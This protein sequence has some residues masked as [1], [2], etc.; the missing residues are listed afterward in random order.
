MNTEFLVRVAIGVARLWFYD[1]EL[2][3]ADPPRV[4]AEAPQD[5]A[6][7]PFRESRRIQ[8][9]A[10][11]GGI[12]G[13]IPDGKAGLILLTGANQR[14][15]AY[16]AG[17][18]S[19]PIPNRLVWTDSAGEERQAVELPMSPR[20]LSQTDDGTVYVV[21]DTSIAWY[22]AKG[23]LLGQEEAPHFVLPEEEYEAFTE[24][25]VERRD[26]SLEQQ[27]IRLKREKETLS[28]I[29]DKPEEERTAYETSRL[30]SL[31]LQVESQKR[32]LEQRR[33]MTPQQLFDEAL[34]NSKQLYRV[35]VSKD[36]VFLVGRETFGYGYAVWRCD[37]SCQ[38]PVQIM[39][40]LSGCCGQMDLQVIGDRLAVAENSRHRVVLA[41]F[42][43]ETVASFGSRDRNA[44]AD[45][46]SGCCNPMNTCRTPDGGLLT[47]ESN[48]VVKRFAMDG[49]FQEIV[50]KASVQSGC[51]NSSVGMA[52]DGSRVYYLDIDKGQ[53]VVLKKDEVI[54]AQKESP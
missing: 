11:H 37:R 34:R 53:I 29:Q 48:G 8:V 21:G 52:A 26:L 42:E 15:G 12:I 7:S 32:Y 44:A 16:R 30:R 46:F 38:N 41:D 51:K 20:G 14:Y 4:I 50:G 10:E 40:G 3:Q 5:E 28:E 18:A 13:F 2:P 49:T 39:K 17:Q 35:A 36:H 24:E 43:G 54:L 27:E 6:T 19:G 1:G 33:N 47:S 22:S 31:T 9:A 45:S 25:A 23:E